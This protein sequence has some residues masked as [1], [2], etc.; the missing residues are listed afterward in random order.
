M[1]YLKDSFF[2]FL[3]YLGLTLCFSLFRTYFVLFSRIN[4]YRA[5]AS[6][7]LIALSSKVKPGICIV[8]C[9]VWTLQVWLY[10]KWNAECNISKH[11]YY[12][13]LLICNDKC[14]SWNV[15]CIMC[16]VQCVLWNMH[17]RICIVQ[18]SLCSFF[19]CCI[20]K[21]LLFGML[22]LNVC[23]SILSHLE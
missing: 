8:H 12:V 9:S 21:S 20:K 17:H 2:F 14:V 15:H 16:S 18:Y 11:V 1:F 23:L 6:P 13:G 3:F 19:C 7:S 4:A 10:F 5:L 22:K